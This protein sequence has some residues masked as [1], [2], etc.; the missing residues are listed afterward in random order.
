MTK[1]RSI[2]LAILIASA[3]LVAVTLLVDLNPDLPPIGPGVEALC[4]ETMRRTAPDLTW[5]A[6]SR[7]Q[8]AD[9]DVQPVTL[10]ELRGHDRQLVRVAGVLHAEF[11][12]VALYSSR[13]V[14]GFE[15]MGRAPWVDLEGLG[16][17]LSTLRPAISDRCVVV[18]GRYSRGSSGHMGMFNGRLDD[19]LR[20][21]VWSTP[22]RP[23]VYKIELPPPPPSRKSQ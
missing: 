1:Q 9:R 14:I 21:E 3:S 13:D 22:H 15:D 7:E 8:R 10:G 20:L 6:P 23:F 16:V 11:E 2:L 18:E 12:W 5:V 4:L 17:N 19:I